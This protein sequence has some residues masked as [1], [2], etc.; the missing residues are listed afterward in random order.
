MPDIEPR[1][2]MKTHSPAG[3]PAI[4]AALTLSVC[5]LSLSVNAQGT[6][7]QADKAKPS[8]G[9]P[10]SSVL[11]RRPEAPRPTG[12][13]PPPRESDRAKPPPRPSGEDQEVLIS[14]PEASRPKSAGGDAPSADFLFQATSAFPGEQDRGKLSEIVRRALS[15]N[16]NKALI[17]ILVVE[18]PVTASRQAMAVKH[19]KALEH[20][21]I[22]H[23]FPASGIKRAELGSRPW[24]L[25]SQCQKP[26]SQ[27]LDPCF[28]PDFIATVRFGN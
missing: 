2:F 16:F 5:T 6:A 14:R 10:D 15:Q 27:E 19:V 28:R 1:T 18:A 17:E 8:T 25:P 24:S 20:H 13:P 7:D 23:G 21:L 12:S 26:A 9:D 22:L 3:L 11:I 4:I